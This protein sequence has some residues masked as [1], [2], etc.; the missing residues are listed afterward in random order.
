MGSIM[1]RQLQATKWDALASVISMWRILYG[2]CGDFSID[3]KILCIAG[4]ITRHRVYGGTVSYSW[5]K[6]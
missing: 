2:V 3:R 4:K 1:V 6:T 5:E